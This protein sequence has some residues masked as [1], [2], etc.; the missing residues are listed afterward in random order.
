MFGDDD[1]DV[2]Q[3]WKTAPCLSLSF[4]VYPALPLF[5]QEV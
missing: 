4:C 2:I 5:G 3:K 1:D